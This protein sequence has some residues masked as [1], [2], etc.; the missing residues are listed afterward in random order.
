MHVCLLHCRSMRMNLQR[1]AS[2]YSLGRRRPRTA[3]LLRHCKA[4]VSCCLTVLGS[5]LIALLLVAAELQPHE[6]TAV[7]ARGRVTSWVVCGQAS[8]CC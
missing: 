8:A 6:H 5:A 1:T 2:L 4:S 3:N 7:S